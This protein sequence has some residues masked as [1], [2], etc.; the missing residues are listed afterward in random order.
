MHHRDALQR[1]TDALTHR[2][3]DAQGHSVFAGCALGH[4]RLAI[5]DLGGGAQPM[6]SQDGHIGVTFNGEIYGYRDLRR[7]FVDFPF[8][9]QSDTEL[10]LASYQRHGANVAKH[11]P[12]MFAFAIWNENE[13]ELL[14]ARDRFGEK[15]L[16]YAS[17]RNGEFVFA[18]E[19]KAIVASGLM[20]PELDRGAMVRYLQRQCVGSD[21]S[22][23]ANIRS[24]PPA[25]CLRYREGRVELSRYW[26]PPAVAGDIG[27]DEAVDRCRSLLRAAIGRE[28][29]ADVPVGA[30][31]SGGLDSTTICL[32]ASG[33]A[34]DLRTFSFDFEGDHSEAVYA[35][36]AAS[37][38]RTRHVVLA[39]G[40]T[41]LAE[42]ITLMQGVYDEPFGDTSAI[43]TYLLAREARRHV[44]VVL[45]GDGGDELFGGYQWYR[46]LL[47][48]QREGRVGLLRWTAARLLNRLAQ[49][50]HVPGAA[51]RELRI[52]GLA[53]GRQYDP[54]LAA[55]RGQMSFFGRS[56]LDQLGVS[57]AGS[58]AGDNTNAGSGSMDDVI[59][60]DV[61]DYMPA[62]ILTKIDRASMAHGLELRA[63][64]L[65]VEFASFCLSLPYRLKVSTSEDKIIL[66]QAFAS[67]W[68][69]SIRGRTKQGFGAPLQ[70]WFK[71]QGVCELERQ[72][73]RDPAAPIYDHVSYRGTQEVLR[74]NNLMQHWTL[75]ILGVWFGHVK[76]RREFDLQR[77]SG[78]GGGGSGSAPLA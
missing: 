58:S 77:Q 35:Q 72:Y 44:K 19:V 42:L 12:G 62:D 40:S 30:F 54:P 38:Y 29:I 65:D 26:S 68:P 75:L 74:R 4:R 56:E 8:R 7:G 78:P 41:N 9:T 50:A 39:A 11:L 67:Q 18:S 32:L 46:P 27:V 23:Y 64:F 76:R 48:M 20:D 59:R 49:V 47:W 45:T 61:Q 73:L 10:I 63:P 22:I 66:R 13:Q 43:P 15:P 14:C 25:H 1:M 17:G 37:A 31:L 16:Y 53:C 60:F 5:V 51:A 52:M 70:R 24:V 33:L 2:G 34:E 21:Q 3:P 28:L 57:H 36:A 6:N 69:E 55:H 71:D